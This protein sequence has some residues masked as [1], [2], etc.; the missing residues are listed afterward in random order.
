M[1]C[2][3]LRKVNGCRCCVRLLLLGES[4]SLDGERYGFVSSY[5]MLTQVVMMG[6]GG[7]TVNG[8]KFEKLDK[9]GRGRRYLGVLFLPL[10]LLGG[11]LNAL[12]LKDVEVVHPLTVIVW[13]RTGSGQE[14]CRYDRLTPPYLP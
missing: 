10:L 13:R 9:L 2:H 5:K 1:T 12:G 7:W 4:Q 8:A 11:A 6:R 3:G 14:R